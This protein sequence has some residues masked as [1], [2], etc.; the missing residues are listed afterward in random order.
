MGGHHRIELGQQGAD[1]D[2]LVSEVTTFVAACYGSTFEGDMTN[3]YQ[4]VEVKNGTIEDL[5]CFEMCGLCS[6]HTSCLASSHDMA[7]S[8]SVR[9]SDLRPYP[10]WV[11]CRKRWHNIVSNHTSNWCLC[12]TGHHSAPDQV[13]MLY[14]LPMF[15]WDVLVYDNAGS[16]CCNE[17]V[18]S[19]C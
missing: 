15:Y 10:D 3:R 14:N 13:W 18:N 11:E 7:V 9:P 12:C 6:T 1:E 2:K 19:S 5:L 8:R 4:N 16:D 17:Q